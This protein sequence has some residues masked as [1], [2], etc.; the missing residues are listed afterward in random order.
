MFAT[1]GHTPIACSLPADEL[2]DRAADLSAL[3]H[4]ALLSRRPINHGERLTFIETPDVERAL[5]AAVA[6]EA[7]CCSF[8]TMRLDRRD[9]ALVLDV[10][11]PTES[12]PIIA[13]LFA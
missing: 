13:A 6:A 4:C 10:T 8:L 2:R 7:A 12:Q 9:G 5:Q 1:P 3:A 11:G